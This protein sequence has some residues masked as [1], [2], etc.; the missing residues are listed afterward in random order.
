MWWGSACNR[1]RGRQ[2]VMMNLEKRSSNHV[3][4]FPKTL[5]S[6]F[7][8]RIAEHDG[9][10]DLLSWSQMHIN[11]RDEVAL[12][13]QQRRRQKPRCIGGS[14]LFIVGSSVVVARIYREDSPRVTISH[15]WLGL[16][17]L[18]H[19]RHGLIGKINGKRKLWTYEALSQIS[20][21]HALAPIASPH[22]AMPRWGKER[23]ASAHVCFSLSPLL[24]SFKC[25][26]RNPLFKV[27]IS[28]SP[29]KV[30]FPPPPPP[31]PLAMWD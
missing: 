11:E 26:E 1:W 23:Q 6:L 20:M 24:Q 22:H 17:L 25:I 29:F 3:E 12:A 30:G 21:G 5:F 9:S 14:W 7:W 15:N 28:S 18:K 16:S 19:I 2:A 8:C 31:P 27:G 10:G 4:R 13:A